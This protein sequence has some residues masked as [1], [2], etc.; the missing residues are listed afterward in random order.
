MNRRT[1]LAALTAGT[2]A[3]ALPRF[4]SAAEPIQ[5]VAA[6][7]MLDIAGKPAKVFGLQMPAG[8]PGLLA[9]GR[10]NVRLTNEL[11]EPT[12]VHWHG[13]TPPDGQD[14]VPDFAAGGALPPK[15]ARSYDFGLARPGTN[16]MHSHVGLQEQRLLAAPLIVRDPADLGLDEQEVVLL[17]HDFTFKDPDEI[18]AGLRQQEIAPVGSGSTMAQQM[19]QNG[20]MAGM[21]D[22]GGMQEMD[23]VAGMEGMSDM[24]GMDHGSMPG[25]TAQDDQPGMAGMAMDLNDIVFDAFLANDRT[26]DDPQVV[27]VEPGGRVRLRIINA[28]AATNFRVDLCQ[29]EGTLI[30]VDGHPIE[31]LHGQSFELA[32]AQ[33]ID[34]RVTLPTGRDA[35]PIL[36]QREGD[37]SRTGIILANAGAQVSMISPGADAKAAA[38]GLN[39]EKRLRSRSGLA[40]RPADRVH[41][42]DLTGSM[43]NYVWT[44]NGRRFEDRQPLAVSRGQRVEIVM[45]NQTMMSH[46]MHLHG[47]SFQ[48]V[49]I[50]GQRIQ[51]ATRDTVLVPIGR[52]VTIAFDADNPGRWAFHC[53]NLYHMA[54]G[55]MTSVEYDEVG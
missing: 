34:V 45:R 8:D 20:G 29:L 48:V 39:L 54:A 22:H 30:A 11:A 3:P 15:Q 31:P 32:M 43:M 37:T 1:F 5:L 50:D 18:L 35:F 23:D 7:R 47:H 19:A 14:G 25:M 24:Q 44:L 26:L 16:W 28:A 55:M 33:R 40:A 38:I 27:R 41:R 21:M 4:A 10:F 9:G 42:L 2:S 51:G 6:T 52:S 13:L 53:H 12:L 49:A 36:A 17:L 46:P